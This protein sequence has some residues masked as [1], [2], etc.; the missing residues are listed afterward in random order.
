MRTRELQSIPGSGRDWAEENKMPDPDDI[1]M[2]KP[3]YGMILRWG[4][5]D[6]AFVIEAPELPGCMA[7]GPTSPE[8]LESA[9]EAIAL[10]IEAAREDG[11]PIPEPKGSL[12]F[13]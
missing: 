3:P 6:D 9:E 5:E 8:A 2:K 4:L 10:W 12:L 13:A 11:L 7:S 1:R